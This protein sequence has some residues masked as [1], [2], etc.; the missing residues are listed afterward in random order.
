MKYLGLL[1]SSVILALILLSSTT[2]SDAIRL[3]LSAGSVAVGNADYNTGAAGM[4]GASFNFNSLIIGGGVLKIIELRPDDQRSDTEIEVT[5]IYLGLAK[6]IDFKVLSLELG[7]GAVYAETEADYLGRELNSD[8][9]V[10]PYV[11]ARL[12]KGFGPLFSLQ[13]GWQYIDDLSGG[14]LHLFQAGVR[15]SF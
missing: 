6:E 3:D 13:G 14:D 9:D 2:F 10:S 7:G 8:D 11:S 15:F 12:V 1:R 5:G 4:A